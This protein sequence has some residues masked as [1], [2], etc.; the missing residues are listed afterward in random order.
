MS[1]LIFS[2]GNFLLKQKQTQESDLWLMMSEL[3][4]VKACVQGRKEHHDNSRI[5][6]KANELDNEFQRFQDYGE[7][8]DFV[9]C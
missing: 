1:E 9:I 7:A 8:G 6:R 4:R 2:D 3:T 5:R